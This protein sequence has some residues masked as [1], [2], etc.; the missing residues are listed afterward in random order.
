VHDAPS[1]LDGLVSGDAVTGIG[2]TVQV[3]GSGEYD[4]RYDEQGVSY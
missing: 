2:E 4:Q 3:H 1:F